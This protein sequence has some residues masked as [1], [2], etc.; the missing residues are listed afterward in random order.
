YEAQARVWL[1]RAGRDRWETDAHRLRHAALSSYRCFE[2]LIAERCPGRRV[3]DFG[4]GNGIHSLAPLRAGARAGVRVDLW[5]ESLAIARRRAELGGA[6]G[7]ASF[8]AMDCEALE[9]P[10][11]R[12]DVVIDG[13]T[14]SSLD[15]DRALPELARVLSPEGLVIGI[16]TLG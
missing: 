11:G 8:L 7:R 10:G 6:A 12:F 1:R 2:G 16:E 14:F 13:G 4:C 15:L 5:E 3:L 9:F